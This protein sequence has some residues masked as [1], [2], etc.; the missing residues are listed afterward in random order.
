ML[1][2]PENLPRNLANIQVAIHR[3]QAAFV[4][5]IFRHRLGL[6]IILQQTFPY[7]FLAIVIAD[8]QRGTIN[9]ANAFGARRLEID[10]VNVSVGETSPTSGEPLY[11]LII[12]HVDADHNWQVL[13]SA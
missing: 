4:L 2:H 13:A 7:D 9:V 11:Q 12:V 3:S 6:E 5:V 8:D 1:N 10:V